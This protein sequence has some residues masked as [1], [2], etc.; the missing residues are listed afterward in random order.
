MSELPAPPLPADCNLR[1]YLYIPMEIER[2][3][4]SRS[5]LIAKRKPE[6][7]F[8]MV[9]L[10]IAAWHEVPAASL[11]DDDEVLA[12]LAM[13]DP[14]R[15]PKV[16][17]DVLRG[18]VKHSDGRLYHQVVVE[19]AL[20]AWAK[21]LKQTARATAGAEA[22]WNKHASSM[23]DANR[24]IAPHM[25]ADANGEERK[26]EEGGSPGTNVPSE[27]EKRALSRATMF[28][29][30]WRI[31]PHKVGK[32]AAQAKFDIAVRNGVD[33]DT[34]IAGV[35]RYVRTKPADHPWAN[36]ST[37]LFQ[38]R[39]LD[40][41]APTLVVDNE[42]TDQRPNRDD[43]RARLN[44]LRDKGRWAETQW[45]PPPSHPDC[46]APYDLLVEY[47]FR[48]PFLKEQTGGLT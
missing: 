23:R 34:L 17:A 39:W 21:K 25:L 10:W 41:P 9:N 48:D 13:C 3:R 42:P 38:K 40:E 30:W 46:A 7:G 11:E 47:E 14:K 19:K 5:W 15:W 43:W 33:L 27:P 18:W 2:L 37:W 29:A 12:D 1:E 22:R 32:G 20:E 8:Y 45:G 4:R 26:G 44:H 36:P 28:E 31:Y 6:L 16:K 24:S 35:E